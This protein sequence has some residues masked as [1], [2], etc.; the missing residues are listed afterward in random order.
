M[1]SHSGQ[2]WIRHSDNSWCAKSNTSRAI[3]TISY[4]AYTIL[5]RASG[6][7]Q[8]SAIVLHFKKPLHVAATIQTYEILILGERPYRPK[9]RVMFKHSWA[10]TWDTMIYITIAIGRKREFPYL[11]TN[12]STLLQKWY[13]SVIRATNL[14][15]WLYSSTIQLS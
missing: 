6:H 11:L 10:L 9:Q 1:E 7:S 2:S 4:N 14:H 12:N 15:L 13:R 8:V 5:S 3:Q